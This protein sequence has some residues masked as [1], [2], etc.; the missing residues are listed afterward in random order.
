[1]YSSLAALHVSLTR[2]R[3]SHSNN[4]VSTRT[5]TAVDTYNHVVKLEAWSSYGEIHPFKLLAWV[6]LD[7]TG[8]VICAHCNY[9]A[10][11]GETCT[12]IAAVLFYIE[13][14]ARIQAQHSS[15]Q[16]KCEW[17]MPSFQKSVEYLPVSQ[18]DIRSARQKKLKLDERIEFPEEEKENIAP[19]SNKLSEPPDSSEMDALY[20][21]LSTGKKLPAVLSL[22]PQYMTVHASISTGC[23]LPPSLQLLYDPRHINSEYSEL[24]RVCEQCEIVISPQMAQIIEKVTRQQ[25]QQKKWFKYRAGRVT[26]SRMKAVCHTNPS[27]PSQS[28]IKSVCYPEVFSFTSKQTSWGCKHEKEG[29]EL[30]RVK[31]CEHMIPLKSRTMV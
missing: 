2:P 10:G 29:I 28:L 3:L 6:V 9:M 26:A 7:P 30:Y 17:I 20:Q 1:M 31:N 19:T 23:G 16:S 27:H 22:V 25:H 12:H 18:I 24:L 15:T 13:T 4:Q 11:L 8:E 5:R 21:Q 14:A